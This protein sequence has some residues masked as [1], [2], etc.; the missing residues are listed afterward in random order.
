MQMPEQVSR[1]D[2]N[3]P[4]SGPENHFIVIFPRLFSRFAGKR[5]RRNGRMTPEKKMEKMIKETQHTRIPETGYR[6]GDLFCHDES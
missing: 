4:E 1:R 2:G 3:P 5:A 6:T